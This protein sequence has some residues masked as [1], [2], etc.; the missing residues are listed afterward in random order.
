MRAS[1]EGRRRP[2]VLRGARREEDRTSRLRTLTRREPAVSFS[3]L[4]FPPTSTARVGLVW[5]K[6]RASNEGLLRSRVALP[7]HPHKEW[8][9]YPSTARMG[10]ALFH[11]ARSASKKGGRPFLPSH[12]CISI[13][14]PRTMSK[15]Q[16][17]P[18]AF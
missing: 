18:L 12:S 1:N 6:L 16:A 2:R 3:S 7:T 8:P 14:P 15:L 9:G 11:R 13:F 4:F 17:N 5:P 10:R